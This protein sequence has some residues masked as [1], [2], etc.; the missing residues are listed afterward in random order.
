[1]K[2]KGLFALLSLLAVTL[3]FSCTKINE[4]TELGDDLLPAVDN[5]NTFDTT[6]ALNAAY[7]SFDDTSKHLIAENM[8]LG[9]LN[10]PVFGS[11]TADMYFNLSSGATG[12][13]YGSYPFGAHRD[14]ILQID[15]VVLSLS[16]QGAYGDTLNSQLSVQVY[17]IAKDNGFNDTT[18]YRF[19]N[20]GFTTTGPVLGSRTNFSLTTLDDSI[21]VR[22][23]GDTT[24][25]V[26]NVLRIQLNNSLAQKL[27]AFDTTS[28]P[29][30]GGYKNDSAF[31]K[32]FRGL[33]IKTTSTTGLGALAYFNLYDLAKTRLI[34]YYKQ[35]T[36]SGTIDSAASAVFT[37]ASYSQANSIVRNPAG[38]YLV[39]TNNPLAQNLYLQSS[40]SG[41][42][43]GIEIPGLENFPNKVIHRAE[44]IANKVPSAADNFFTVPNLLFLDRKSPDAVTTVIDTAYFFEKDITTSLDGNFDYASFGGAIRSDNSYRFNITRYV[45]GIVTRKERNDSLRLYAPLRAY[46]FEPNS[47]A[48]LNYPFNNVLDNIAK[49][50]VVLGGTAHPDPA[51]RLRLRIVY[52]N[53]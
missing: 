50:R 29:A 32:L 40:P 45:Q 26:A 14:S 53:L 38:E 17:E 2:F 33:A 10:D 3:F 46:V 20:P 11:T 7:R 13:S 30:T 4:A 15:S 44:L 27:M 35:K 28:D 43:I 22:R 52:S 42:Y 6:I 25:K 12:T 51:K 16:Y 41:S 19:S 21:P 24:T 36:T 5:V 47:K 1:M 34:V 9:K 49:G 39:N 31:R 8:A 48:L 18:L 37:H 23:V